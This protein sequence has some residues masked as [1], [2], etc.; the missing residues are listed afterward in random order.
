MEK[1]ALQGAWRLATMMLDGTE[2]YFYPIVFID[3]FNR[4]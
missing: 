2:L 1:R 3:E 4:K